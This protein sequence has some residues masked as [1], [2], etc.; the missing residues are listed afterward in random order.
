MT[1]SP[2]KC[3]DRSRKKLLRT[4]VYN[5]SK[6]LGKALQRYDKENNTWEKKE[7]QKSKKDIVMD[8]ERKSIMDILGEKSDFFVKRAIVWDII[9]Y[10]RKIWWQE[11]QIIQFKCKYG[12]LK[13]II[14]NWGY[15]P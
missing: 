15:Q 3:E 6:E 8:N 9:S 13:E 2:N 14:I 10:S 12:W 7:I 11:R 4:Q 1:N 5:L